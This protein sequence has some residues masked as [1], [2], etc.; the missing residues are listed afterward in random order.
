MALYPTKGTLLLDVGDIGGKSA[1]AISN[2]IH[3][4]QALPPSSSLSNYQKLASEQ[5]SA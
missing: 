3:T 4:I 1:I 5:T 2:E